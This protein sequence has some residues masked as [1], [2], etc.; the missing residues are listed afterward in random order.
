MTDNNCRGVTHEKDSNFNNDKTISEKSGLVKNQDT[1]F[2]TCQYL[3][4][5]L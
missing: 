3:L 2:G 5:E 1:V 4:L